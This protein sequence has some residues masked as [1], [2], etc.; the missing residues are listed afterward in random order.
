M[1]LLAY[2]MVETP[3]GAE[4]FGYAIFNTCTV[5]GMVTK[6]FTGAVLLDV[7]GLGVPDFVLVSIMA[8]LLCQVLGTICVKNATPRRLGFE[9]VRFDETDRSVGANFELG[10]VD[11]C[12]SHSDDEDETV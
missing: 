8:T 11:E 3:E 6:N 7:F 12:D 5:G 2:A 1:A 9:L 4:E 10:P